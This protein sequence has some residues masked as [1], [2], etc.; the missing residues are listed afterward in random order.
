MRDRVSFVKSFF[1]RFGREFQWPTS[2][3]CFRGSAGSFNERQG[4][5]GLHSFIRYRVSTA[6]RVS[7]RDM[8]S[9][10]TKFHQIQGVHGWQSFNEGACF[11]G[12]QRDKISA[13]GRGVPCE[14]P[15]QVK[16]FY[17]RQGFRSL[18]VSFKGCHGFFGRQKVSL[19][20]KVSSVCIVSIGHKVSLVGSVSVKDRVSQFQHRQ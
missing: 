5:C 16:V 7:M 4:L 6:G 13:V 8:V 10:I 2:S 12:R 14:F 11:R 19:R 15:P 3:Q 9:A 18:A 20:D 1:E 17:E